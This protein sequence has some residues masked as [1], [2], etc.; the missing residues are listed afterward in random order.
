MEIQTSVAPSEIWLR[1]D[2]ENMY[3][4]LYR[5][6]AYGFRLAMSNVGWL[7][8]QKFVILV[9]DPI[10]FAPWPVLHG[11]LC[12]ICQ[13]TSHDVS[14]PWRAAK[15]RQERRAPAADR[16]P[17][18]A[19]VVRGFPCLDVV[20][21]SLL[22]HALSQVH[23]QGDVGDEVDGVKVEMSIAKRGSLCESRENR[24][25]VAPTAYEVW[26][27]CTRDVLGGG[28]LQVVM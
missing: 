17:D 22:S 14:F 1:D 24:K 27:P 10:G 21:C 20:L 26:L 7:V 3:A 2:L 13:H 5:F 28:K 16:R 6:L 9:P 25:T 8:T 19:C 11:K 15:D 23:R 12:V 4:L 18:S